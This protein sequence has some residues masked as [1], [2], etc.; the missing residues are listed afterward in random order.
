MDK[1]HRACLFVRMRIL[2]TYVWQGCKCIGPS[3]GHFDSLQIAPKLTNAFALRV[4][5]AVLEVTA[6]LLVK[7]WMHC[8]RSVLANNKHSSCSVFVPPTDQGAPLA[9]SFSRL[10]QLLAMAWLVVWYELRRA[11]HR[12]QRRLLSFCP[13]LSTPRHK[14]SASD[15]PQWAPSCGSTRPSAVMGSMRPSTRVVDLVARVLFYGAADGGCGDEEDVEHQSYPCRGDGR[16]GDMADGAVLAHAP[17]IPMHGPSVSRQALDLGSVSQLPPPRL[18]MQASISRALLSPG[19]A[20]GTPAGS[21]SASVERVQ[22]TATD[23]SGQPW[24]HVAQANA[25]SLPV[26]VAETVGHRRVM[27]MNHTQERRSWSAPPDTGIDR[28]ACDACLSPSQPHHRD[29]KS[30]WEAGSRSSPMPLGAAHA[31]AP[32]PGRDHRSSPGGHAGASSGWDAGCGAVIKAALAQAREACR[33]S[34]LLAYLRLGL[35]G[36]CSERSY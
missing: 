32:N 17:V 5:P 9:T 23:A 34:L 16:L 27:E 4:R 8:C 6:R 29:Q 25:P 19:A 36:M 21:T 13:P 33:A 1:V 11:Q 15:V 12:R 31:A 24:Q 30:P 18:E 20:A 14:A 2:V 26:N 10:V 22:H 7:R 28:Q 3:H 35:P